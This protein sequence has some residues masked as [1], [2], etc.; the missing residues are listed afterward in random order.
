[1]YRLA[2]RLTGN[3]QDAEDLTQDAFIRVFKSLD[4]Y[5]P[6]TFEG[7][8]HRI[9]TNLFLD[10]VRRKARIRMDALPE[11]KARELQAIHVDID[12]P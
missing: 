1:M 4:R 8:M 2:F 12:A 6:G 5:K 10:Q 9:V 11:D 7:W 3:A